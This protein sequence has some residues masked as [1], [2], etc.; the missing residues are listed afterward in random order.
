MENVFEMILCINN[1]RQNRKYQVTFIRN[2][3]SVFTIEGKRNLLLQTTYIIRYKLELRSIRGRIT[4][5]SIKVLRY[6]L[7]SYWFVIF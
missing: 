2:F 1:C 6:I 7:Q 4:I 3:P 5:E